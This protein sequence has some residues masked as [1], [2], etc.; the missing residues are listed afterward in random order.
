M[1]EIQSSFPGMWVTPLTCP[2]RHGSPDGV[3]RCTESE[4]RPCIYETAESVHG[5]ELL[6]QMIKEWKE[7]VDRWLESKNA[8]QDRSKIPTT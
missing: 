7:E 4:M 2:H 3:D 8:S 1:D 6:R 5:C